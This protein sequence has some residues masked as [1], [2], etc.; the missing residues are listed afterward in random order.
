M[1]YPEM[2]NL[3]MTF[4]VLFLCCLVLGQGMWIWHIKQARRRGIYPN[5]AKATL[6]DVK[7]LITMGEKFLAIRLYREIYEKSNLK[8]AQKAVDE[9]EKSIKIKKMSLG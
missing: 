8:E 2:I 9:M 7:R 6:F 3:F 4:L 1:V 5:T